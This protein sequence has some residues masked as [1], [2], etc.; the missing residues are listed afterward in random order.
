[1]SIETAE[2]DAR[3]RGTWFFQIDF[4]AT[5]QVKL[6]SSIGEETIAG[7]AFEIL[8]F[9]PTFKELDISEEVEDP[10]VEWEPSS[11]YN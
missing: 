7:G 10:Q 9:A 6:G 3:R 5:K 11:I 4:V 1:M 2:Q 8:Q